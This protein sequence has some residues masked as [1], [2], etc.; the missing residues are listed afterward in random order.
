[1]LKIVDSLIKSNTK[2]L[3]ETSPNR[4]AQPTNIYVA[5]NSHSAFT[6]NILNDIGESENIIQVNIVIA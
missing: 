6:C 2:L 4:T 3:M 5:K 1:M